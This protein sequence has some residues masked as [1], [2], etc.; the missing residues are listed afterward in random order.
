L[1]RFVFDASVV[2]RWFGPHAGPGAVLRSEFEAGRLAV[3]VPTLLFLEILN[4]AGRQWR[5][6]EE[7]LQGLTRELEAVKFD[8]LEARL[9]RV[10]HW[11][12]RGLTAYDASYVAL[13][14][15]FDLRLVTEDLAILKVAPDVAIALGD[16]RPSR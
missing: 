12:S 10:A 5:W 1:R 4:V 8:V 6:R 16:V 11:V 3:T 7:M 9:D 2:I 15:Q 14:E 13:A